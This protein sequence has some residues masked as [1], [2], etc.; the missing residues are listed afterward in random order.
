[1]FQDKWSKADQTDGRTGQEFSKCIFDTVRAKC[2]QIQSF[3]Q[4]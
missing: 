4:F 3:V 1:M 2:S